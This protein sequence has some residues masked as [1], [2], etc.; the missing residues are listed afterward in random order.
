[1]VCMK[2]NPRL[3]WPAVVTVLLGLWL[4]ASW[5]QQGRGVEMVPYSVFEQQL[6]EGKFAEVQ[7]GDTLITGKL[8]SPRDGKSLVVSEVMEPAMAERLSQYK[9]PFRRVR[10]SNWLT[11]LLSWLA[12]PLI[13]VGLLYWMNRRLMGG[14]PGGMGGLL[15]VGRSRAKVYMEKSTGVHFDDVAGVDE[16]KA[17]LQEIVDFLKN[18]KEHGRARCTRAQG[19]AADGPHR[20]R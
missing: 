15:G 19:R 11:Q 4:F 20:H 9:V 3:D 13:F 14:G 1:M 18:P 6:R 16:A 2:K 8:A 5:W 17:E 10:E 7:V 12:A